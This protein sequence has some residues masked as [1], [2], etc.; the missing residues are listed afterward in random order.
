MTQFQQKNFI[1]TTQIQPT[2]AP[3]SPRLATVGQFIAVVMK[4][5]GRGAYSFDS[6]S[7]FLLP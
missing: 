4:F 3:N 7:P 6:L 5:I 2:V 1:Q